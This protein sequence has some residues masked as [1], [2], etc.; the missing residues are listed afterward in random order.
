MALETQYI[1]SPKE[2]DNYPVIYRVILVDGVEVS[3]GEA[4]FAEVKAAY[5]AVIEEYF[6]VV[7]SWTHDLADYVDTQTEFTANNFVTMRKAS[8]FFYDFMHKFDYVSI[9][10]SPELPHL[11]EP[12]AVEETP[13]T[14]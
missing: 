1:V 13:D 9:A 2:E 8:S 3:R 5:P 7:A 12:P 6:N 4:D 11:Q 10:N 14:E